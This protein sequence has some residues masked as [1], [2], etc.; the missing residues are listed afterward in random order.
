MNVA[1]MKKML[2][3][4]VDDIVE[5]DIAVQ[6]FNEGKNEMAIVVDA[7][8][9]DLQITSDLSDEFAFDEK[10]HNAPVLYAAA[11]VKAYDSS[12]NEKNSFMQQFQ[13]AV[14]RFNTNYV[15]PIQFRNEAG[16]WHYT[17]TEDAG[18]TEVSVSDEYYHTWSWVKVYLDEVLTNDAGVYGNK[19][20]FPSVVPKGTI[21]TVCWDINP[22]YQRSTYY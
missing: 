18:V 17:V 5:N 1:Q 8:F 6:L 2:E 20:T 21:I 16:Y 12:L 3:F 9:P 19:I 15:V 14:A 4:Y 10:Y 13:Q 7:D 11:M 22:V